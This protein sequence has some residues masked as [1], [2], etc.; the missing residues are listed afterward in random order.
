MPP[1]PVSAPVGS[2]KLAAISAC[3]LELRRT[4]H[5]NV[6]ISNRE[7]TI[8]ILGPPD[9]LIE[10][11]RIVAGPDSEVGVRVDDGPGTVVRDNVVLTTVRRRRG[12]PPHRQHDR[13]SSVVDVR[14]GR[15]GSTSVSSVIG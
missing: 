4:L 5:D 13:L 12:R 1:G 10:S 8:V 11:N 14:V 9:T 3:W 7:G 15:R 6:L 2:P